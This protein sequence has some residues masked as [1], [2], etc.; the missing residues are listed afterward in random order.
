MALVYP[1]GLHPLAD[2]KELL[3]DIAGA[4]SNLCIGLS[5]LGHSTEFISRVGED[6]LGEVVRKILLAEG[7]G[8][9]YLITDPAAPTGVFFRE[10]L[11]DGQR[12]V[13]YYR[14]GSAASRLGPQDLT[15]EQFKGAKILHLTGITPALSPSC[16]AACERAV[17]LARQAGLAVSF[18][19]NYR[20]RLW[21]VDQARAALLPFIAQTDILLMGHEDARSIFGI[22]DELAAIQHAAS[23]GPRLVVMKQAER[24][25]V[26]W[27][28]AQY[29]QVAAEPVEEVV[30][31]VG[32][33]DGFDAGFLSGWLRGES[34]HDSLALGAHVGAQAVKVSGDYAGY[35]R[36]A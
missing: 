2:S 13:Y 22:D 26:L 29:I 14:R 28:G 11:P 7:V 21:S 6:P 32:A 8:V 20:P 19:P 24:G 35:P 27:D 3:L 34:F 5:R 10:H 17:T 33:G 9:E 25:A 36:R 16:A 23:L 30:D 15:V 1:A 12:R 4:E 18:D 31:P